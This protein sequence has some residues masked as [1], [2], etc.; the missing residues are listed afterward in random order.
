MSKRRR[1]RASANRQL[2]KLR[3]TLT[4]GRAPIRRG[5]NIRIGGFIGMEAAYLDA[6][7]TIAAIANTTWAGGEFDPTANC[8]NSVDVGTGNTG[9][10]G[11]LIHMKSI[12][13]N[14]TIDLNLKADQTDADAFGFGVRIML[15]L[16]KQTNGAQLNAEDVMESTV[17]SPDYT[18]FRNLENTT[19][20][21]V[22][23]DR[24]VTMNYTAAFNDATGA[25]GVATGNFIA[26]R[27]HFKM[28][29]I[30]KQP[31]RVTFKDTGNG[32]ADITDNSVHLIVCDSTANAILVGYNS[33]MRFI[34][35]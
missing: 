26:T 27:K 30:W 32:V 6:Q 11:R 33:R 17:F 5:T 3:R 13:V 10:K 9:R 7:K 4:R 14:G 28:K 2:A 21:Q 31:L 19:R 34:D 8:L 1:S 24:T 23:A 22:L 12:F 18:G 20:F 29:H 16:D 25:A 35:A 15:I